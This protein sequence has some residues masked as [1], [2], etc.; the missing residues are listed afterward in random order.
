MKGLSRLFTA[1]ITLVFSMTAIAAIIPAPPQ[2]AATSYL[3]MDAR[4]G[5]ILVEHNVD[6]QLP[7]AS[8][9]KM[10]TAYIVEDE[11]SKGNL[12]MTDTTRISEKA[13]RMGGSKMFVRVDSYVSISDLL[14]GVVIQSGND[15]SVALAEHVAGSEEVFVDVMNQYANK[16]GLEN[17]AFKNAT[18]WPAP[19]HLSTARDMAMLARHIIYD[20]PNLYPLYSEK[21][22]TYTPSGE[23]PITQSNRNTLL[24]RNPLVDGLKTG[25]TQEAGYCLV[26]S[27]KDGDTRFITVVMGTSSEEARAQESQK[28]LSYGFRYYQSLPLYKSGEEL[29]T[30]RIWAGQSENLR[31]GTNEDVVVTIP[32]GEE[33]KLNA[34]LNV[35]DVIEAPIQQGDVLGN[36][37]VDLE[38]EVV[39][40]L[41]LVA[42]DSVPQAGFFSRMSDYV[43]LFFY[44]LLN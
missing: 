35:A 2:L 9:T 11:I 5:K 8:L 34:V 23:N 32:R 41:P 7:P 39:V 4:T 40:D 29:S 24:R 3:L 14:R 13:W 31:L 16:L 6:Q 33:N 20:H 25:H 28:L 19:G 38:G 30:N 22:F 15:A 44:N 42:L 36:L 17:T 26:T 27:A 18:G 10:M 37:V 43:S 21:D 1:V 12:S